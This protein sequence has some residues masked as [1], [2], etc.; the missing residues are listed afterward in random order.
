MFR[1]VA[2]N[3]KAAILP[4]TEGPVFTEL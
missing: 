4:F 1:M 3:V 2:L